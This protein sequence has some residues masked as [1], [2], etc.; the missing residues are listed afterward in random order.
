M[1]STHLLVKT[2]YIDN[3]MCYSRQKQPLSNAYNNY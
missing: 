1:S 3:H 2:E